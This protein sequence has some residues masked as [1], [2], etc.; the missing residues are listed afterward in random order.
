LLCPG[1]QGQLV[2]AL[3]T[4]TALKLTKALG[5][6]GQFHTWRQRRERRERSS[7]SS[8]GENGGA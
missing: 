7:S 6:L 2:A 1:R 4:C 3:H 8:E 5:L